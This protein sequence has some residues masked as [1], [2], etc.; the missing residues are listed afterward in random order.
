[1]RTMPIS[2]LSS[3]W[4]A[5]VKR[6]WP[7]PESARGQCDGATRAAL[8]QFPELELQR[9]RG[10]VLVDGV[11]RPHWWCV[12]R[13]GEILDP[14]Q[15]QWGLLPSEY[16]PHNE[17]RGEPKCKCIECGELVWESPYSNH[18]EACGIGLYKQSRVGRR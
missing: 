13:S 16:L 8:K 5:W 10:Y 6:R 3:D 18:C 17:S 15:H 9:V 1:M 11:R 4:E 14:T 7:T 2:E 12:R